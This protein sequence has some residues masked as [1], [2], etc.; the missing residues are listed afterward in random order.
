MPERCSKEKGKRKYSLLRIEPPKDEMARVGM[1]V[2]ARE[3][4]YY[5]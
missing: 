3:G 1:Q 4:I 2:A 5:Y